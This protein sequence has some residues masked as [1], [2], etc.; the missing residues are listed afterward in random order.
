MPIC[1][2][3]LIVGFCYTLLVLALPP[4][5]Q[6]ADAPALL[7]DINV[8]PADISARDFVV[9][10]NFIFFTAETSSSGR[11]LWRT[12]GSQAGTILLKDIYPGPR[13]SS[14]EPMVP[15]VFNGTPSVV[16]A[17][18]DDTHGKELWKSDGTPGGTALV[19]DINP[20]KADSK[21]TNLKSYSLFGG[22]VVFSA[23][24]GTHGCEA[25]FLPS[26]G[27]HAALLIDIN[28]GGASSN[29]ANFIEADFGNWQAVLFTADDGSHGSELW[30]SQLQPGVAWLLLDLAQGPNSSSPTSLVFDAA[31]KLLIF[32]A[33]AGATHPVAAFRNKGRELWKWNGSGAGVLVAD[34]I[35]GASGSSPEKL[36]AAGAWY[37]FT[38]NQPATGRELWRTDSMNTALRKDV[39]PGAL[40][41]YIGNM[42]SVDQRLFFNATDRTVEGDP[43]SHGHE[44]WCSNNAPGGA[45]ELAADIWP[46]PQGSNPQSLFAYNS[47]VYFSADDG[48]RGRELW[49]ATPST[50]PSATLFA[51]FEPGLTSS[52]PDGFFTKGGKLYFTANAGRRYLY[53]S[54]GTP[55]GTTPIVDLSSGGTQDSY[56]GQFVPFRNT[57]IFSA[58]DG[59]HGWEPWRTDGST[60]GTWL[61]KDIYAGSES[62]PGWTI[63]SYTA[64]GNYVFMNASDTAHGFELWRTDG[65]EAGTLMVKDIL[66]GV[67]GSNP[68]YLADL[69]G[70]LYFAATD[71]V[72]GRE[73]WRSDGTGSGTYLLKDINPNAASSE[74]SGLT[75]VGSA[76]F[77]RAS[78][79][80][81]EGEELWK[82]DGTASGT[83]RVKEIRL[84]PV[85]SMPADFSEMDG[86]VYFSA[87]EA[88]HGIELWR[89]DGTENGTTMVADINNVG[90][91]SSNPTRLY[92]LGH[93]LF[94]QATRADTGRELWV[95]DGTT[96]GTSLVMDINPGPGDGTGW[97]Y[98]G[99]VNGRLIFTADDG[100]HGLELWSSDGTAAGTTML[101]DFMPGA[102]SSNPAIGIEYAGVLFFMVSTGADGRVLW[103]T[104]GTPSGTVKV[105]AISDGAQVEGLSSLAALNGTLLM[106][107]YTAST[108][109]ELWS[110]QYD[111]C[112]ADPAKLEPG[113]CGCGA[114]D[115]DGNQ[116]SIAD[117]LYGPELAWRIDQAKSLMR[118]IKSPF[119]KKAK[120]ARTQLRTLSYN[121]EKYAKTWFASLAVKK[122]KNIKKLSRRAAVSLRSVA[123]SSATRLAGYKKL[124]SASLKA[125]AQ[126]FVH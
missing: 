40:D 103:R 57:L 119:G 32:A 55:A 76:I 120:R 17:A 59:V 19:A 112:P 108:G 48:V 24:E 74:P 1:L 100:M 106:Q 12:D 105:G 60:A 5:A 15:L 10:G 35:A 29:P 122:G 18:E 93:R 14:I 101:G 22:G 83:V 16:F 77:F 2:S 62:S 82:S 43:A 114:A 64:S 28:P 118:A 117:C 8:I 104:D 61:I 53:M 111:K 125:L 89:S 42:T 47:R 102:Y 85:G 98:F 121:I 3:S 67:I 65:T 6:G 34:I 68:D 84:G 113:T 54:D 115:L 11:E 39:A 95:S 49:R 71:K 45:T 72:H 80:A 87:G 63:S 20:G 46:G 99:S 123:A 94:F 110:F 107:G 91:G 25:W 7:K 30:G 58:S 70:I 23:C 31:N 126:A 21:P 66:D 52:Y 38:A 13:W 92:A 26:T 124:A 90:A 75:R 86:I 73:L 51:D 78:G 27:N 50:P 41:S 36:M 81:P 116:N 44:L 109:V 33:D 97:A 9:S 56:P 96:A 69:G 79:G 88:A 4:K 37:N